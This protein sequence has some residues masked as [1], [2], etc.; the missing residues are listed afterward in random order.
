MG[1]SRQRGNSSQPQNRVKMI[2]GFQDALCG[3]LTAGREQLPAPLCRLL[4]QLLSSQAAQCCQ[5]A[6]PAKAAFYVISN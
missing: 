5:T 2:L 1:A 6:A 4:F 3:S